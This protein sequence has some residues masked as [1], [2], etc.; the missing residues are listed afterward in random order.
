MKTKIQ[1]WGNSLAVRIPK[2]F[3]DDLAVEASSEVELITRQGRLILSPV[4]SIP[5]L[6]DLLDAI[7]DDMLHDEIET[8]DPIG[9]ENW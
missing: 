2:A 6:A 3:A 5:S 1:R 7:T 4:P 8:G 9:V